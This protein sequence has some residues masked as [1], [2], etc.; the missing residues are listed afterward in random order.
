MQTLW[1]GLQQLIRIGLYVLAGWLLKKGVIDDGTV[2]GFVGAG[3]LVANG[4]WTV[5]WNRRQVVT[6]AGVENAAKDPVS[7]VTTKTLAE[8]EAAKR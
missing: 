8:I 7:P 3:V 4:A 5:W 1:D 2:E 6:V